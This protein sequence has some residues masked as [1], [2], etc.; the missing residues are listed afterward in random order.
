MA[1]DRNAASRNAA[2]IAGV[3]G[4]CAVR[5]GSGV[6]ECGVVR[7]R[8]AGRRRQWGKERQG[9]RRQRVPNT[10][11]INGGSVRRKSAPTWAAALLF[12]V[13]A[14]KKLLDHI[15][16]W[17]LNRLLTFVEALDVR[18]LEG[19]WHQQWVDGCQRLAP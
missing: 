13:N 10:A 2:S 4:V 16:P 18:G 3:R 7:R 11:A 15:G 5:P 8:Q 1:P 14:E 6:R 19:T 9:M 12:F 17:K